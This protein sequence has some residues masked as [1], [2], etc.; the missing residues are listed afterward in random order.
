MDEL[1][2]HEIEYELVESLPLEQAAEGFVVRCAKCEVPLL[3]ATEPKHKPA[4]A[5]CY[6]IITELKTARSQGF[7][8]GF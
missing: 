4:C 7:R 8:V 1:L 3:A 5:H 6:K 2:D